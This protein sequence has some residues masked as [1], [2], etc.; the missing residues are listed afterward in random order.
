MFYRVTNTV[1]SPVFDKPMSAQEISEFFNPVMRAN[2]NGAWEING[3]LVE[4]GLVESI[5]SAVKPALEVPLHELY[6]VYPSIG[7][8]L[9][10]LYKDIM[11]GTLDATG[12]FASMITTV[13]EAVAKTEEVLTVQTVFESPEAP[14][15]NTDSEYVPPPEEEP[16]DAIIEPL[17]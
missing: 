4:P 3:E 7:E 5:E 1:M 15:P 8:Q 17:A 12:N 2:E 10:A 13:K 11:A 9:D 16:A 6:R 14:E